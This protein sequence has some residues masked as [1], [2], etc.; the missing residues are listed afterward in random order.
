MAKLRG[1]GDN[2]IEKIGYDAAGGKVILNETQSF[3]GVSNDVWSYHIGGYQV[4]C[5]WLKDRKG[6]TLSLDKIKHYCR[7]VTAIQ[8]TMEAQ[9]KVDEIYPDIEKNTIEFKE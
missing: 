4:C 9:K 7:M 3:D 5:K 6:N 2:I 8:K 1:K